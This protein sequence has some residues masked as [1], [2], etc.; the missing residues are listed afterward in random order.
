MKKRSI[1]SEWTSVVA[2]LGSRLL[3]IDARD[4][5]VWVRR[6]KP[7]PRNFSVAPSR[8]QLYCKSLCV[9]MC[10]ASGLSD[11]MQLASETFPSIGKMKV[12][13]YYDM[14]FHSTSGRGP[15]TVVRLARPRIVA[16][17][18]F[19]DQLL[20]QGCRL[21]RSSLV[22]TSKQVAFVLLKLQWGHR[23]RAAKRCQ[24][25]TDRPVFDLSTRSSCHG[26]LLVH[27]QVLLRIRV[28]A[29]V[30]ARRDRRVGRTIIGS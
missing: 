23:S 6:T 3:P 22:C 13:R 30:G 8:M 21:S 27:K 24:S 20:D 15:R 26:L 1:G 9:P 25:R 29:L 17:T 28:H 11:P 4:I 19:A 2:R 12:G 16:T 14:R 10:N 18:L 5:L 7:F